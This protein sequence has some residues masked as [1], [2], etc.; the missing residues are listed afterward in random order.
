MIARELR[1]RPYQYGVLLFVESVFL[2]AFLFT[3]MLNVRVFL[4]VL[5]WISYVIWGVWSH[6][7]EVKTTRLVLEYIAVGGLGA[8][9]LIILASTL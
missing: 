3:P 2:S 9:M 5:A 6:A 8:F 7:G 4:A 1:F